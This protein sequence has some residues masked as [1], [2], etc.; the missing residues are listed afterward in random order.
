MVIL[1]GCSK[2]LLEFNSLNGT[3]VSWSTLGKLLN[4][5]A[6][7]IDIPKSTEKIPKNLPAEIFQ[8]ECSNLKCSQWLYDHTEGIIDLTSVSLPLNNATVMSGGI[9]D[10]TSPNSNPVKEPLY[11]QLL[12]LCFIIT[13]PTPQ[14]HVHQLHQLLSCQNTL[15]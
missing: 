7:T 2:R 5:I 14:A 11:T 3:G 6:S 10:L 9:V 15:Y 8:K 12:S 4:D 1:C 13:L